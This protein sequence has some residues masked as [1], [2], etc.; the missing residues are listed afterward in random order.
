MHAEKCFE[1]TVVGSFNLIRKKAR[2]DLA[3]AT[4]VGQALAADPFPRAGL[5]GTVAVFFIGCNLAFHKIH[6]LSIFGLII[7][8]E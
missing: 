7:V 5:V 2:R 4:V 3:L 1:G 8:C 6:N